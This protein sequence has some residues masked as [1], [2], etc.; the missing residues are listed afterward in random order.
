MKQHLTNHLQREATTKESYSS[1]VSFS[2]QE[3][4]RCVSNQRL[5][6]PCSTYEKT[7]LEKTLNEGTRKRNPIWRCGREATVVSNEAYKVFLS[8]KLNR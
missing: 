2:Y 6:H 7:I 8:L 4:C 3:E 5:C 1:Q